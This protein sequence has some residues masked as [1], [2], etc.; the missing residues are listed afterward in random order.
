MDHIT[1]ADDDFRFIVEYRLKA[2]GVN[3]V[4]ILIV[5]WGTTRPRNSYS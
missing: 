5:P 2:I 1:V 3:P 4:A